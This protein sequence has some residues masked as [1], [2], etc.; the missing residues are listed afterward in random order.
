MNAPRACP[1]SGHQN[2]T[3]TNTR[4]SGG[5]VG[6][7]GRLRATGPNENKVMCQLRSHSGS[8]SGSSLCTSPHCSIQTVRL[9]CLY[10]LLLS[11]GKRSPI[12]V[13]Q[14]APATPSPFYAE[15]AF[16]RALWPARREGSLP[17]AALPLPRLTSAPAAHRT[18]LTHVPNTRWAELWISKP[19]EVQ[20]PTEEALTNQ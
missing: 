19:P 4:G 20:S 13:T 7:S 10:I 15:A 17:H 8:F 14:P 18:C 1:P 6:G 3:F 9:P 12:S 16:S 11:P 2:D 5:R